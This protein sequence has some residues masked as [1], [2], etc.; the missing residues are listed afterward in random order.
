M[1]GLFQLKT[2]LR[3]ILSRHGYLFVLVIPYGV[4]SLSL[5]LFESISVET[6]GHLNHGLAGKFPVPDKV[7]LEG[8]TLLLEIR[9]RY[10]WLA[11]ALL[12]IGVP[13]YVSIIGAIIITQCHEN[14][15]LW[16]I[17]IFTVVLCVLNL[18]VLKY[19]AESQGAMYRLIY[20]VTT[21]ALSHSGRISPELLHSVEHIIALVNICAYIAPVIVTM[22]FCSAVAPPIQEES[23]LNCDLS[24]LSSRMRF[25]KASLKL[26]AALL[27][28]GI[29]HM[30]A[31][32]QWP[33]ALIQA[34]D[35]TLRLNYSRAAL[36][37]AV[38]WGAT[39]TLML[40]LTYG[41][42]ATYLSLQ[43]RKIVE[44]R[45]VDV[46]KIDDRQKW[47]RDHDLAFTF[48]DQIPQFMIM[49]SPLVAGPLQFFLM[50]TGNS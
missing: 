31:W 24:L 11:S 39:F 32:L 40:F 33:T 48:G 8:N 5:I 50:H 12:N 43:A 10:F 36:S 7:P 30:N 41:P 2:K 34:Q 13:V 19:T 47:L 49:L 16:F 21:W 17:W 9:A 42:A 1:D 46:E 28:V 45:L 29:L 25:L 38:Y 3:A 6:I 37:I 18:G 20:G 44:P 35:D 27:V 14:R 26:A 23:S 22:A 4:M 15:R